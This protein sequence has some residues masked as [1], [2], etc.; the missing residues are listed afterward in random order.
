MTTTNVQD[1][2]A[3]AERNL[4]AALD[5][6]KNRMEQER[7][8]Q[9][10]IDRATAQLAEAAAQKARV[11]IENGH[12]QIDATIAQ[13]RRSV[14]DAQARLN[15]AATALRAALAPALE[16]LRAVQQT[17]ETHQ[18]QAL[19]LDEIAY[20]YLNKTGDWKKS[21]Q[22]QQNPDSRL[23]DIEQR[24]AVGGL[25]GTIPAAWNTQ[26]AIGLFINSATT[27]D[28]RIFAQ[29]VALAAI[30]EVFGQMPSQIPNPGEN[31]APPQQW[32]RPRPYGG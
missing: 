30:F 17:V 12:R 8:E 6:R 3:E 14:E 7:Q 26:H 24:Q 2:Y 21:F 9:A 20:V 25:V 23:N 1:A 13:N 10:A 4:Q 27:P 32:Q 15:D 19:G 18:N 28:E 11:D 22:A 29:A 31:Y 5:K 16:A